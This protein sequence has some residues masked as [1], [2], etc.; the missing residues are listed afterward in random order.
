MTAIRGY[1]P[2]TDEKGAFGVHSLDQFV[3]A[4][5]DLAPAQTFYS[6]FGLDVQEKGRSVVLNTF[7]HDHHWGSVVE[8]GKKKR[9]H[10]LS[11]GCFAEDISRMKARIEG[12]GVK[13]LDPPA[14]F[15]S[16]GFWFRDPA[17]LLIEIKVA[18][19]TSPDRKS[20][21]AWTPAPEGV[22]SAP[23]RKIAGV[24]RPRRLAHCLIF[25]TDIDKAINFYGQNLGLRLSDRS[26]NIVA[27]MHGIY[28]SDHHMIAFAQSDAPGLHHCS[29]DV[30]DVNQV[31]LG[32]MLMADKGY[33]KGWG[34]GRHVLGSNFFHYVQDPWG[35]FCEYSSDIDYIPKT[36][37]WEAGDHA[38]E[39]SFYLWG[40]NPP[41]DFV[42]NYEAAN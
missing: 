30:P 42:I 2:P 40:P 27:F 3:L 38:P 5:P 15:E 34:L 37:Q 32:A 23:N 6:N 11:F 36:T 31:G 35:S 24:V 41:D 22:A 7:G 39:D 1:V 18:P 17:G 21:A 28:G 25:T 13:L 9:L 26:A 29:W 4:V 16:N 19:K 14:G 12:N 8:D 33:T 10:H 20:D